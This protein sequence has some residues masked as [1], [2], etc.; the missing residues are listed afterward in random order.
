MNE[1]SIHF[2]TLGKGR[3]IKLRGSRKKKIITIIA[4]INEIENRKTRE[5][6]A[7]YKLSLQKIFPIKYKLLKANK[8]KREDTNH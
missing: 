6:S 2:K 1:L 5:K 7:K 8:I 3:H 4:E